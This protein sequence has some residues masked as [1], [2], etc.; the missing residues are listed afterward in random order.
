MTKLD[1]ECKLAGKFKV[2]AK[3]GATLA[4]GMR[5]RMVENVFPTHLAII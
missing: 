2:V 1:P 4:D 3:A 5:V